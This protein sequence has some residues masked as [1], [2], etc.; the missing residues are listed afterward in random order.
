MVRP[1]VSDGEELT[2]FDLVELVEAHEGHEKG[3]RGTTILIGGCEALVDF[4]WSDGMGART[5]THLGLVPY[6]RLRIVE[7]RRFTGTGI[8]HAD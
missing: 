7:R 3:A 6:E 4:A 5:S 8:E 1:I 2:P